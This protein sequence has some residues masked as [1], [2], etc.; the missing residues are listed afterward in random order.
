MLFAPPSLCKDK[1]ALE[2]AL[3]SFVS[4]LGNFFFGV[5]YPFGV[6]GIF[7]CKGELRSMESG[8]IILFFGG[9][10]N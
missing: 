1:G 10:K 3:L 4:L 9:L 8:S 5:G 6:E 7:Y 2:I